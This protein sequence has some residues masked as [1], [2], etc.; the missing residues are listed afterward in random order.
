MPRPCRSYEDRLW[1]PLFGA[2]QPELPDVSIP[3]AKLVCRF[4]RRPHLFVNLVE[5]RQNL[6]RRQRLA[7]KVA[8]NL[9]TA[10]L[11]QLPELLVG[12]D[13]FSGGGHPKVPAQ[14]RDGAYDSC[15]LIGF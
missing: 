15:G 14:T 11:A 10:L 13:A 8:L 4:D 1:G 7:E 12:L 6:C 2:R 3:G 5:Q 9:R